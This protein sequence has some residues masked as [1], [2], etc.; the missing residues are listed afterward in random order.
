M[1]RI[2]AALLVGALA[3]YLY[4][5]LRESSTPEDEYVEDDDGIQP[6]DVLPWERAA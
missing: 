1:T 5:F 6:A 3:G 2:L 4:A